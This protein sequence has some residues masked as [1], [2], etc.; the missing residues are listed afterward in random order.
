[1]EFIM[2]CKLTMMESQI[3]REMETETLYN[4]KTL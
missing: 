3:D 4:L 1:M 2:R